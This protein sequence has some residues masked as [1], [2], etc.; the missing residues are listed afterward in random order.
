MTP[1][2]VYFGFGHQVPDI[3]I[4][5]H[6]LDHRHDVYFVYFAVTPPH[7]RL[8]S[9]GREPDQLPCVMRKLDP[10]SGPG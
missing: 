5:S 7:P 1:Q 2:G 10:G 8:R 6:R 4:I 9:A 3:T